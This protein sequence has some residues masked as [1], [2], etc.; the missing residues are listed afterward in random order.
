MTEERGEMVA[1]HDDLRYIYRLALLDLA[2]LLSKEKGDNV[3]GSF[4][5]INCNNNIN[6]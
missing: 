3:L 1:K 5:Y 4:M 6:R 2:P